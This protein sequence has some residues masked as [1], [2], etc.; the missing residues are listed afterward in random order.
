MKFQIVQFLFNVNI[1]HTN[2]EIS[3]GMGLICHEYNSIKFQVT[4]C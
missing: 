2:N 3:Q 1:K 4:R